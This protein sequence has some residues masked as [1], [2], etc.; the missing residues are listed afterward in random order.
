ML[1][2]PYRLKKEKDFKKTLK[3]GKAFQ[4][5]FLFLKHASNDLR[6]SRFGFV[7]SVAVSKKATVRNRIKRKLREA[8][9][10]NLSDIKRGRDVVV[11]VQPDFEE[12]YFSEIK[13][14]LLNLYKK[15]GLLK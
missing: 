4:K 1:P 2:K 12:M 10:K 15:A 11:I 9:R 8:T 6:E 5:E 14:V 13:E 3:K 7:V